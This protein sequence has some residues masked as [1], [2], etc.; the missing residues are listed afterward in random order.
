M[1]RNKKKG[2]NQSLA[3][4]IIKDRFAKKNP[5]RSADSFVSSPAV[6]KQGIISQ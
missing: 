3:A 5:H 1:G 2:S 6:D 4:G